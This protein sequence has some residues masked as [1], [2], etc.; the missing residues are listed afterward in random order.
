M[1]GI[2]TPMKF[3]ELRDSIETL[4]ETYAT[5]RY[6]VVT[7]QKQD[8]ADTEM[9]DDKR[10][11][12]LFY[13]DGSYKEG[14]STK[15]LLQHHCNFTLNYYVASPALADLATLDSAST[16]AAQKTAA[17]VN[18]V[19]SFSRADKAMDEFRRMITQIIMNPAHEQLGMP[20]LDSAGD[21]ITTNAPG[22]K[23]VS[24]RWLS[25]F[26]KSQPLDKGNLTTIQASERLF[27]ILDETLL[28]VTPVSPATDTY[29]VQHN[30]NTKSD[31]EGADPA[32]FGVDA[33]AT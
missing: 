17:L 23:Q 11:I 18:T 26:T 28:G 13:Q 30:F 5:G 21:P 8:I 22:R 6:Q 12:Q 31:P 4:L 32:I 15:V 9:V 33:N 7:G 14:S 29:G 27:L 24:S 1:S 19:T 25:T 3:E 2:D 16:T 20:M 10:I